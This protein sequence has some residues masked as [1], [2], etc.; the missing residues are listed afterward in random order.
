[1]GEV[2]LDYQLTWNEWRKIYW[3]ASLKKN[4]VT[5]LVFFAFVYGL[6]AVAIASHNVAWAVGVAIFT[7]LYVTWTFGVTPKRYWNSAP[8]VQEAKRVAVSEEGVLRTSESLE[9]EFRWEQFRSLKETKSYFILLGPP[10]AASVYLP[11]RALRTSDDGDRLRQMVL[12][13]VPSS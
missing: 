2:V 8:D 11:K 10:G 13:H 9:E 3:G 5:F 4:A 6:H 12:R 1:M 7:F